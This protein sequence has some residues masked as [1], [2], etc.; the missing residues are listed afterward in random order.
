MKRGCSG[1]ALAA[2]VLAMVMVCPAAE[3]TATLSINVLPGDLEG[4]VT[5]ELVAPDGTSQAVESADLRFVVQPEGT[6]GTYRVTI[7]A[8]EAAETAEF[9]VPAHGQVEITF[10]ADAA[11]NKI[12]VSLP[13][14]I[15]NV[16]VTARRVE[17]PL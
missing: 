5:I 4:P 7:T 11:E 14:P 12:S 3:A 10:H 13:G 8:G 9:E 16:M 15:E 17:E 1:A 6:P 2:S